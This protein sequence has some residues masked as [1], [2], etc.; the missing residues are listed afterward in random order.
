MLLLLFIS[1]F[2]SGKCSHF[3]AVSYSIGQD[4]NGMKI[5]RTQAWRRAF[6]G[7]GKMPGCTDNDVFGQK[8][9]LNSETQAGNEICRLNTGQGCK[10]IAFL[11]C[12]SEA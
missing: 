2:N 3:R 10:N 4:Q 6:A 9:A 11:R 8:L 12:R 1:F 7:Y 5:S